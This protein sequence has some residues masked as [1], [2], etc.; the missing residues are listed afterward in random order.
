MVFEAFREKFG[1][2]Y[3][4]YLYGLV[5]FSDY[6]TS[7]SIASFLHFDS[8][9]AKIMKIKYGLTFMLK[10]KSGR[11]AGCNRKSGDSELEMQ[12][13]SDPKVLFRC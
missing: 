4:G 13:L 3:G 6:F 2:P 8:E 1:P 9:C 12:S 7:L 5:E 11:L 10:N